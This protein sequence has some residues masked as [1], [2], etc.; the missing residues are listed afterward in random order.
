MKK[1]INYN[2]IAMFISLAKKSCIYE[3]SIHD[4]HENFKIMKENPKFKD[5]L[6]K[7]NFEQLQ[8]S[9][10]INYELANL[11]A[12]K[13]LI[14]TENKKFVFNNIDDEFNDILF[15]NVDK[16]VIATIHEMI[17]EFVIINTFKNQ[18]QLIKA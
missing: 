18:K 3:L 16:N 14:Y 15:L 5:I 4:I 11:L 7:Y 12:F 9:D 10:E 13:K 1:N 2:I 8:Y 17:N 6:D